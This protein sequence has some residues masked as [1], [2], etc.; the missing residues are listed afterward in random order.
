VKFSTYASWWIWQQLGRTADTQG[1]LI[2]TPVHW[3]QL[4]RRIGRGG[5]APEVDALRDAQRKA[6]SAT[7]ACRRDGAGV[8]VR[9]DRYTGGRR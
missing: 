4:R 6:R 5:E 1:A 7:H 2:R 8:P 3:N 9:L